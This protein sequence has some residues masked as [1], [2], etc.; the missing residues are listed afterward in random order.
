MHLI[1]KMAHFGRER[2]PERAVY[3]RADDAHG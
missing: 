3:A 1:E 2:I